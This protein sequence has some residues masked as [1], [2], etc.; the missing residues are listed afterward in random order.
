[1]ASPTPAD[2]PSEYTVDEVKDW[3][4]D[5]EDALADKTLYDLE[6]DE[7]DGDDRT[8]LIEWIADRHDYDPAAEQVETDEP[9][10][11]EDAAPERQ[12]VPRESQL[13][14]LGDREY[15]P[16][17]HAAWGPGEVPDPDAIPLVV[18]NPPR[19]GGYA[20]YWFEGGRPKVVARNKRVD[21]AIVDGPL[22]Y[23]GDAPD[24]RSEGESL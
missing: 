20:G 13:P 10:S 6:H 17:T 16:A 14:T 19:A 22:Q 5:N 11:D 2:D 4:R 23:R 15:D 9:A 24:G 21:A 7:R 1:M 8:T 18:V 3:V 12:G